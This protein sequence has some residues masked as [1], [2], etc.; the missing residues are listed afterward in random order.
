MDTTLC[1][2]ILPD[3]EI[4]V[5]PLPSPVAMNTVHERKRKED[6]FNGEEESDKKKRKSST[7]PANEEGKKLRLKVAINS[8]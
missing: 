2:L 3:A 4:E 6:C 5:S 1:R 8:V 7:P